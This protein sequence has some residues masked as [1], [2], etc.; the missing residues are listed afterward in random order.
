MTM[1]VT[2]DAA[3]RVRELVTTTR[4][5][6][7]SAHAVG[8]TF[9]IG[10]VIKLCLAVVCGTAAAGAVEDRPGLRGPARHQQ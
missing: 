6:D 7:R 10:F 1:Q 9:Q 8:S 4:D 3:A 5:E 2:T